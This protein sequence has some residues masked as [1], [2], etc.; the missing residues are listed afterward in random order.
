MAAS[1]RTSTQMTSWVLGVLG[2]LSM[3]A[4]SLAKCPTVPYEVRGSIALG[5]ASAMPGVVEVV[6]FFDDYHHAIGRMGSGAAKVTTDLRG[7]FV[8]RG[9]FDSFRSY[10]W[11][12]HD[13]KATPQRLMLILID[14]RS[15]AERVEFRLGEFSLLRERGTRVILL[16]TIR[17][18]HQ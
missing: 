10:A 12:G 13:C 9:F 1:E 2:L 15:S 5:K 18:E 4:A 3:P 8:L 7:S 14:A 11:W 17:L 6:G 16:P